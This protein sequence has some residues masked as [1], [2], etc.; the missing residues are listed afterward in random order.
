MPHTSSMAMR[1]GH[2]VLLVAILIA[3]AGCRPR[4]PLEWRVEG[5][6]S[7]LLQSW[8]DETLAELPKPLNEEFAEAMLAI[9]DNTHGWSKAPPDSSLN[10]LC[11]RL[12]NHTVRDVL[13][14]GMQLMSDH[15]VSRIQSDLSQIA[16]L[17][18]AHNVETDDTT[19]ARLARRVTNMQRRVDRDKE[20]VAALEKRIAELRTASGERKPR[21]RDL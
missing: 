21:R 6:N 14:E 2:A 11:I 5:R 4:D 20:V 13:I 9:R 17:F 7:I 16:R 15:R 12:R 3:V 8:I 1:F 10:P 18:D 19:R